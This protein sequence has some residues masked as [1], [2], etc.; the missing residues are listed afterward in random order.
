MLILYIVTLIALL[1][2]FVTSRQR[3]LA[4]LKMAA[5]RLVA[6]LPAFLTMLMAF[7]IVMSVLPDRLISQ[8]VGGESGWRGVAIASLVGSVTLMPGFVAFPLCAALL[9]RGVSYMVLSAFTTTLM[10][11]GVLTYPI[12]RRY[13][14]RNVTLVRNAINFAI[15]LVV[16]LAMGFAFRE[17]S[18]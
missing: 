16:A 15:A 7:S 8:L 2:S 4:A 1:A 11:V 5:K 17:I 12:E 13:L 3:T 18:L 14:G 9:G 10:N 6:I